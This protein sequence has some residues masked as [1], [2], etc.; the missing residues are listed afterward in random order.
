MKALTCDSSKYNSI[1]DHPFLGEL[2][3]LH[4]S[5]GAK[6]TLFVYEQDGDY[7]ISKFPDRFAEEFNQSADWLK[8]GYHAMSPSISRD[9]IEMKTV[10]IP[11]FDRVDSILTTKFKRAKSSI[12]RLHYFHATQEE[13][14][15]LRDKGISTLLA[16]DD[17]RIS[18]SLSESENSKLIK[19]E[20][21]E[22]N[23]MMYISTDH[24]VERDN[25]MMGLIKNAADDEFVI[26]THEWAYAGTVHYA[27]NF[28]VHI[29]S[30]LSCKFQN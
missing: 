22:K 23:G 25:T 17:D 14:K 11:S 9:S 12:I 28:M 5:T 2:K 4:N 29:L 30:F 6:F 20:T 1:F 19:N 7:T 24:R 18:Y 27:Y 3:E 15:H 16:A 21:L 13:V 26:F 10:F 8:I